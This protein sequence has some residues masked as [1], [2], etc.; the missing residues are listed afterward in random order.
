MKQF[1]STQQRLL[2]LL[3]DGVC[4][5]G[6]ELG[7]ALGISRTAIWKQINQ[8]VGLGVSIKT[9]A[10]QGYQLNSP[11]LLLNEQRIKEHLALLNNNSPINMHVFSSVDSTNRYLKDLPASPAL[12]VC[13]AEQ[14]T[15]GRGRFGRQW[16]S[17]FGE[18]IYCSSR[19]NFNCDLSRLSGLSLVTSLSVL[20]TLNELYSS[21]DF[22][23]KWPNDIFWKDKKICGCLIEISAESN[24]NAQVIIGIGLNTNT[25][26]QNQPLPDKPWCSLFE[27]TH[28]QYDR[29]IIIAKLLF[30]LKKYITTFLHYNLDAFMDEWSRSDYLA[31]KHITVTQS[32][33]SISGIAQG[34]NHS[35]QLV[36]KDNEGVI[37]YCSSGD[38]SLQSQ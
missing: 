1:S 4:H 32:L 9:L 36:L 38:T 23:I 7:Q 6:N 35:G 31:G 19:W 37:H 12:E 17:P 24:S 22:K 25:D 18:N 5:S 11:L 21:S 14:Q 15:Q 16:I 27:I 28:Q 33:K 34:I 10:Q 3:G 20:T 30:N 2:Q 29:N 8:L 13:C 26:T